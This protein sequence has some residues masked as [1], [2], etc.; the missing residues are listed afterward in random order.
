MAVRSGQHVAV[1]RHRARALLQPWGLVAAGVATIVDAKL[2]S[3]A[4]DLA[5]IV[6]CLI[7]T[8]SLLIMEGYAI[9]R[10][11]EAQAFLGRLRTW[12]DTHTDQVIV[13]A[14]VFLGFWLIGKS[15]YSITTA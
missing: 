1:V 4:N 3:A 8:S 11:D 12:I 9:S 15:I 2:A 6:F 14:S 7:A 10:P 13:V 5:V